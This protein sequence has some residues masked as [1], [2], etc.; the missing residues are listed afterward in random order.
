MCV[1]LSNNELRVLSSLETKE[2]YGLGILKNIQ[3][4][5]DNKVSVLLGSLYNLLNGLEKKGLV[6]SRWGTDTSER[7]GNRRRYYKITGKGLTVLSGERAAFLA[8]W[9]INSFG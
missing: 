3:E 5:T 1:S 8:Q 9:G 4:E 7:G 6:K 2:R